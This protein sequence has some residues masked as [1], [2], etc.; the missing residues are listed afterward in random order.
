MATWQP[1]HFSDRLHN[2]TLRFM[3]QQQL[4]I[5]HPIFNP[6]MKNEPFL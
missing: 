1:Q 2:T 5:L 3:S 4:L 6:T